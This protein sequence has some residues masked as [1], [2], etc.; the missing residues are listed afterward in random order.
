MEDV[1][2]GHDPCFSLRGLS[3]ITRLHREGPRL[4]HHSQRPR[5]A[6]EVAVARS[7]NGL[8][9]DGHASVRP[10]ASLLRRLKGGARARTSPVHMLVMHEQPYQNQRTTLLMSPRRLGDE[11]RGLRVPAELAQ[12]LSFPFSHVSVCSLVSGSRRRHREAL[13]H[14]YDFSFT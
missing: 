13:P 3:Y 6:Q 8:R 5:G 12:E 2:R 1:D 4:A 11:R 9:Q 10:A 14:M 7:F